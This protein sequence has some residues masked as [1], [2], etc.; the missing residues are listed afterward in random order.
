MSFGI[1]KKVE[2]IVKKALEGAESKVIVDG[3][4]STPFSI[5][6]RV[7][8]GDGLYATL[9]NLFHKA[10]KPLEQSNTIRTD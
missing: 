4:I 2:R 8:Q 1:P 5:I 6:I 7:R 10:L 9:F 3:R